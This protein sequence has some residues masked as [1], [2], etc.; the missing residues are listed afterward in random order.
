MNWAKEDAFLGLVFRIK[1]KKNPW[2]YYR[3]IDNKLKVILKMH[4][5]D[6]PKF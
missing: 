6:V 2:A 4:S 5:E 1:K 3:Q